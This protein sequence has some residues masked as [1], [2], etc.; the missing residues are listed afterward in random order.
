MKSDI[1]SLHEE[2]LL[3]CFKFLEVQS[4][5]QLSR[6]CL[7]FNYLARHKDLWISLCLQHPLT[8]ALI[9]AADIQHDL[10]SGAID[11]YNFFRLV[12]TKDINGL[13]TLLLLDQ[14]RV[15]SLR[16]GCYDAINSNTFFHKTD[17]EYPHRL[18]LT[19]ETGKKNILNAGKVKCWPR[20]KVLVNED[21]L[22]ELIEHHQI[23]YNGPIRHDQIS[24][25][26]CH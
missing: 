19:E 8:S 15:F 9:T 10:N 17:P 3:Y 16:M 4:L 20:V 21:L 24:V 5:I 11:P 22:R 6:T 2:M 26:G 18:F 7:L 25:P 14:P 13:K 12:M 23:A 1:S